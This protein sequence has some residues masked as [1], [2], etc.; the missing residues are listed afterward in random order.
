MD[1]DGVVPRAV[2]RAVRAYQE[3]G[4]VEL[5]STREVLGLEIDNRRTGEENACEDVTG[6]E[7]ACEDV[8]GE[9]AGRLTTGRGAVAVDRA[10]SSTT[11]GS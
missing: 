6:E 3:L 1:A 5:S 9:E 4:S 10:G 11:S 2:R 8:T 7:N